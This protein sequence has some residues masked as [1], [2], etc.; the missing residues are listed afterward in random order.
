MTL[1]IA[2]DFIADNKMKVP[3]GVP[4]FVI[5]LVIRCF[6]ATA[7]GRTH[8]LE[9]LCFITVFRDHGPL[10]ADL[11]SDAL[12]TSFDKTLTETS[13]SMALKRVTWEVLEL[14]GDGVDFPIVEP[15]ITTRLP[16]AHEKGLLRF[17]L[18]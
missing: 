7:R 3:L 14:P 9:K 16:G 11:A 13:H 18:M 2:I 10:A 6:S 1:E 15:F 4:A 17:A 8:P 5:E 12:W